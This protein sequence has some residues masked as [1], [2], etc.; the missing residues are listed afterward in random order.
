VGP[1]VVVFEEERLRA[2]SDARFPYALTWMGEHAQESDMAFYATDPAQ[3]VV[4]PGICRVTYG[5]FLLSYPPGLLADVWTD[6][7]YAF[8]ET[9]GEVLLLAAL[10]HARERIVVHVG[11]RPPRGVFHTI[12]GRLDRKI[13]HVP[14]GTLSPGTL[15]R[16]RVMHVLA[17]HAKRAV[18]KDY[19]W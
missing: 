16:L 7:D 2:G 11:A 8:A 10:D 14:L 12:A 4:G 19:V 5:G 17:G 15:R 18:A 6:P 1:V 9:K 3:G 13:L